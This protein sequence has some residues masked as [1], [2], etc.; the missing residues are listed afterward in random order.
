[1]TP[2]RKLLRRY[3]Y[4]VEAGRD[5][6]RPDLP[7]FL[8]PIA[9]QFR[10][11]NSKVVAEGQS[12]PIT[13]GYA[14]KAVHLA[15][16]TRLTKA[17]F[18]NVS[19]SSYG[20]LSWWWKPPT[21]SA[22]YGFITNS[23]GDANISAITGAYG[24]GA[25]YFDAYSL[26]Q[27]SHIGVPSVNSSINWGNWQHTLMS[28]DVNHAVNERIIQIY[29]DD[30]LSLQAPMGGTYYDEGFGPACQLAW[31]TG[32]YS[33]TFFG[34]NG[35]GSILTGDLADFYLKVTDSF[36]DL[37][38][39]ANRRKFIDASKKP[40]DPVNFPAGALVLLTGDASSFATNQGVGGAFTLVGDAFTDAATSPSD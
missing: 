10:R 6:S 30:A 34:D 19:D 16:N 39:E 11:L 31:A 18:S 23:N 24:T 20:I 25:Y 40:V 1:M 12:P 8:V 36:Y 13:P 17:G 38:V 35:I 28:W 33:Y 14:A 27:N 4:D 2:H 37:S 7:N 22:T 3:H 5:A 21:P 32:G 15:G 9:K 26:D 29:V